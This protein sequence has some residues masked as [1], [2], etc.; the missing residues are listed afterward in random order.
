MDLEKDRARIYFDF[1]GLRHCV[2]YVHTSGASIPKT[3]RHA[4]PNWPYRDII[5]NHEQPFNPI[6]HHNSIC[7]AIPTAAA[8]IPAP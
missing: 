5:A 4:F 3:P 2:I 7:P 1:E 8:P 6:I